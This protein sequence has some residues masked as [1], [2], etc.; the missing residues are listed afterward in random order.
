M[1]EENKAGARRAG[2]AMAGAATRRRNCAGG[3][4]PGAEVRGY[5]AAGETGA[6]ARSGSGTCPVHRQP[7]AIEPAVTGH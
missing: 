5:S 1:A 2:K 4:M 3:T 7:G 6:A